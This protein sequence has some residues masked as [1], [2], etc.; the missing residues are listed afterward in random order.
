MTL[1]AKVKLEK[2]E[3]GDLVKG[4]EGSLPYSNFNCSV[5][6]EQFNISG[7][8]ENGAEVEIPPKVMG[9]TFTFKVL[10]GCDCA[11]MNPMMI[12]NRGIDF[13]VVDQ[14][15]IAVLE[16]YSEAAKLQIVNVSEDLNGL[17]YISKYK[18]TFY[19]SSQK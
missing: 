15:L 1:T 8:F 6:G 5:K 11:G 16:T 10:E 13:D 2:Y 17:Y 12:I 4:Y 14:H 3:A 9:H 18:I 7:I 19:D